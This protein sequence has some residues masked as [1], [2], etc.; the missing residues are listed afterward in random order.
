MQADLGA[1]GMCIIYTS[2]TIPAAS[3]YPVGTT[4]YTTD[5]GPVYSNGTS[6]LPSSAIIANNTLTQAQLTSAYPPSNYV[7]WTAV[8]TD[9]GPVFSNGVTWVAG[10]S[11]T[12]GSPVFSSSVTASPGASVNNY[13]PAGYVAGTTNRMLLLANSGDTTLTGLLAATDGWTVYI[14]NTSTTDNL[15]FSHL[16]ASS[17]AANQFSCS[18][19]VGAT[20]APLSGTLLVY[21][22]NQWTF[23]S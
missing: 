9:K 12:P 18:Q 11:A 3:N 5:Q 21:V 7:G 19:G 23:A 10:G 4:A 6:W 16:S 14:R 1:I 2:L 20:V 17:S 8:T 22:V 13:A 15:Q